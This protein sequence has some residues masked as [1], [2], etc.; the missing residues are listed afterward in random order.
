MIKQIYKIYPKIIIGILM[1]VFLSMILPQFSLA[2]TSQNQK[3]HVFAISTN[4]PFFTTDA[5]AIDKQW[6]LSKIHVPQAWDYTKG[7][8]NVIVAIIDT[9]IHAS[10][11]ELNDGRVIAGYNTITNQPIPANSNSDDNGHGTD[12]AGVIGAIQNN[13]LGIAGINWNIKLMP[14]K[15]IG[16]DGTGD[17]SAV[18]AGIVWAADHGANIINLSLGGDGFPASLTL[19]NAIAYAYNRNVLIV[20]AAGNDTADVGLNLNNDPV[21][22]VCADNGQ[23]MVL[24]VA[25]TDQND[26]K[27][28]FSNFGAN[29]VDI[30]AP[31]QRI[32]TTAFLPNN[33]SDNVLIYGSGTSMAAPVVASTAALVKAA[34]PNLSNVDLQNILTKTADNIDGLNQ[35]NCLNGSCNGFL[36]KGRVNAL[37]AVA[38]QPIAD[39]SLER[40]AATGNIYMI[41]GNIKRLVSTFV[42]NQRGFSQSNVVAEIGGQLNNFALGSPLPP[43]EGTLVKSPDNP[44]V[45][46]IYQELKRPLTYLVFISRGLSFANIKTISQTE[47]DT[48]A[49]SDWYWP[50][51]GTMVLLADSPLVY[52][53]DQQVARPITYFVFTQR[54]L[55]FAKVVKVTAD[56]FSHVPKPPDSF[57]LAPVEGTLIKSD[58]DPGIYVI[59]NGTRQLLSLQA[60]LSRGYSF[61]DVK[62]LP[63]AEIDVIAPGQPIEQ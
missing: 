24:G 15:A 11:I 22:P 54:H 35:T 20:A 34:Y 17:L 7:S 60:F 48:Y 3:V 12:V 33:P 29:C 13:N 26:Q 6:Y 59:Q 40:E 18:S 4:D 37:K 8:S 21:Y 16:A 25:A 44:Q 30:S 50:P 47:I 42:F 28:Q 63:Q 57:W 46:V 62:T 9:G 43:L 45:Y 56:E 41:S 55:S 53:M 14:V 52:V 31:G 39:G 2:Q 5:L 58:I 49:A 32:L 27:A 19:S 36:G 10:H 1:P 38:P 61:S 51:D 23:N